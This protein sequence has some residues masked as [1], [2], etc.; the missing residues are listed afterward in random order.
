MRDLAIIIRCHGIIPINFDY[1]WPEEKIFS[2]SIFKHTDF[3]KTITVITLAKMA[4]VC[5]GS[6]DVKKYIKKIDDLYYKELYEKENVKNTEELV[7]YLYGP[8]PKIE[9]IRKLNEELFGIKELFGISSPVITKLE[10]YSID[11]YY[12]GDTQMKN[13]GIYYLSSNGFTGQEIQMI[14]NEFEQMSNYLNSSP[15]NYITKKY[16]FDKLG[17]I[18][19]RD[20]RLYFIDLTCFAFKN[21]NK[22]AEEERP[23]N[24]EAIHWLNKKIDERKLKGG[25]KRSIRKKRKTRKLRKIQKKQKKQKSNKNI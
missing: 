14:K 1:G 20:T 12:S 2:D 9:P 19:G 10:D 13:L 8:N 24:E 15:V 18:L 3:I 23:L 5:Y 17:K 21:M 7:N 22:Q 4:G 16:I 11:K 6:P 25:K